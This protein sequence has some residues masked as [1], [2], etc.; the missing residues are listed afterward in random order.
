MHDWS[1]CKWLGG[2][3]GGPARGGGAG[4]GLSVGGGRAGEG[5]GAG[6]RRLSRAERVGALRTLVANLLSG[7][8]EEADA[9]I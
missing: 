4:S 1:S 6:A 2:E 7:P 3:K 8:P 9:S 5:G